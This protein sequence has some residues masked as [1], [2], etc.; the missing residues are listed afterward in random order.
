MMRSVSFAPDPVKHQT[1]ST[2]GCSAI[3][4][5]SDCAFAQVSSPKITIV[6]P[7]GSFLFE[8]VDWENGRKVTR[9]RE[10]GGGGNV[11]KDT[12]PSYLMRDV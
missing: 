8:P 7:S 2:S 11:A 3:S 6:A 9:N 1:A 5:R 10:A 4:P 12:A